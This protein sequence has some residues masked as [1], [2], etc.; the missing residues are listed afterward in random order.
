MHCARDESWLLK[1]F[2]KIPKK[3][4]WEFVYFNPAVQWRSKI[5]QIAII[6]CP[7]CPHLTWL[8]VTSLKIS[9]H[10]FESCDHKPWLDTQ[11]TAENVFCQRRTSAIFLW[12][13][14][15]WKLVILN[16]S[17]S[18]KADGMSNHWILHFVVIS[19][20]TEYVCLTKFISKY[21]LISLNLYFRWCRIN[22]R[23][24]IDACLT[25]FKSKYIIKLKIYN[26][27]GAKWIIG[28]K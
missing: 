2:S 18:K 17:H 25:K 24:E 21:N 4:L 8:P 6:Y 11:F 20:E 22:V 12:Q 3:K 28:R 1:Y 13:C 23:D 9:T 26:L 16:C 14:F 7:F 15:Q 5:E 27:G 10:H 19:S